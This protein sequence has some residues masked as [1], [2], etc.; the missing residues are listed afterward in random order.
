MGWF[1]ALC[2]FGVLTLPLAANPQFFAEHCISCHGPKKSKGKLRLDQ[3]DALPSA[4]RVALY[5]KIDEALEFGDMPPEDEPQPAAAAVNE[6]REW[7]HGEIQAAEGRAVRGRTMLIRRLNRVEYNNTIRDL[8][9]IDLKPARVFPEDDSA[10]G[11]DN[12]GEALT[13]SPLLVEKYLNA[14]RFIT[15][16]VIQEG[17][18]PEP[19]SHSW[20]G[21]ELKYGKQIEKDAGAGYRFDN[22]E[23]IFFMPG[24]STA[25]NMNLSSYGVPFGGKRFVAE[26]PGRYRLR[27]KAHAEGSDI[28]HQFQH[29]IYWETKHLEN[30][31]QGDMAAMLKVNVDTAAFDRVTISR[32]PGVYEFVTHLETGQKF[33]YN[34]E[35]APPNVNIERVGMDRSYPGPAM[36]VHWVEVEGPIYESWPPKSHQSIFFKGEAEKDAAYAREILTRFARRAFRRPSTS[37]EIDTLMTLFR[38]RRDLDQS[39]EQSI[40]AAI[41]LVLVSPSFIYLV[42]PSLDDGPR[43]LNDH[44]LAARLSYFL[45]SSMPDD[46]LFALADEGGLRDPK[47][48][49]QQVT[50]MLDD[51]KAAAFTQ[52]FVGQWLSLR[53]LDQVAVDKTLYPRYSDYLKFL[54]KRE[55]ELFFEEILKHDLSVLSFIDS[56]FSMLNDRLAAHY[57]IDGVKGAHFRRVQLQPEHRRGGVTG[58]GS[59]LTLTTC[60]TRTSPVM[61]G[62]WVLEHIMGV[63]P[64]PPPKEIPAITPDTQNTKTIRE[65]LA[66]HR[67]DPSCARCHN[68]MDPLGLALENYN[69]VGQWRSD[70]GRWGNWGRPPYRKGPGVD[71]TVQLVTGE[72]VSTPAEL[73]AALLAHKGRFCESLVEKLLT[74]ALGRG[75]TLAD[76]QTVHALKGKLETNGYTLAGLIA[77]IVQSEPFRTK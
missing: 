70:Y 9:G 36:V 65:L 39:F 54:L 62:A 69:V 75:L 22:G 68:K 73:R 17:D 8:F 61:R 40:A 30:F 21:K 28:S 20:K 53:K 42:E 37:A 5:G 58:H 25:S 57:G 47:T 59:V 34:F 51:P 63:E 11:F 24:P 7:L 60:G 41:E 67:E 64:P 45:W 49:A 55:T 13:V 4:A 1:R 66:K 3:M 77:N 12:V 27:I 50:R 74:Y 19:F 23:V 35:N 10:H 44:E 15:D 76:R 52:N 33:S 46:T 14:A 71:A 29:Q 38:S 31:P 72:T 6:L 32:Q 26:L 16:R 43:Q 48:L 56:D 2:V 18:R